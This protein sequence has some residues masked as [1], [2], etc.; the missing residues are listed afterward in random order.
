VMRYLFFAIDDFL[1]NENL[2]RRAQSLTVGSSIE[3]RLCLVD[4]KRQNYEAK[5]IHGF[6][7]MVPMADAELVRL[8]HDGYAYKH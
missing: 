5:D 1:K 8:Q 3:F 6:V 7:N 2:I 4:A